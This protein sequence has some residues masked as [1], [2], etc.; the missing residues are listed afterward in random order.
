V[1]RCKLMKEEA[2][3]N[4]RFLETATVDKHTEEEDWGAGG[5]ATTGG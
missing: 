2:G 3:G 4:V 5:R 1:D